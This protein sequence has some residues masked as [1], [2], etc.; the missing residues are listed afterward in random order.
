MA[1]TTTPQQPT[2]QAPK[3]ATAPWQAIS[4]GSQGANQQYIASERDA[5]TQFADDFFQPWYRTGRLT[6]KLYA[7][8]LGLNGPQGTARA[9]SAFRVSPGYTFDRWL[10]RLLRSQKPRRRKCFQFALI[11]QTGKR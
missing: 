9:Q 10:E 4:E 2:D 5:L 11:R 7:D 6:N 8:A 3:G 1:F